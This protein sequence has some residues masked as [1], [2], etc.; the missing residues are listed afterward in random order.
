[1]TPEQL[2]ALATKAYR[3]L[4][5]EVI[6]WRDGSKGVLRCP[7]KTIKLM[8]RF[9]ELLLAV[10]EDEALEAKADAEDRELEEGMGA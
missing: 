9:Q 8:N 2:T 4:G 10:I 6:T 3:D 5:Y 7:S 1:M